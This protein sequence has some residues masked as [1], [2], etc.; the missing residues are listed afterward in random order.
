MTRSVGFFDRLEDFFLTDDRSRWTAI[1]WIITLAAV[2]GSVQSSFLD[3]SV[4]DVVFSMGVVIVL[5]SLGWI[6]WYC[7]V[8]SHG[9]AESSASRRR[10]ILPASMSLASV[11]FGAAI[12]WFEKATSAEQL[13]RLSLA[14]VDPASIGEARLLLAK[15]TDAHVR[16]RSS[17]VAQTGRKFVDASGHNAAAWDTALRFMDYRSS[18]NNFFSALTDTTNDPAFLYKYVINFEPDLK[19]APTISLRGKVA[20]DQA[21][22]TG[23]IGEDRNKGMTLGPAWIIMDGGDVNIDNIELRNVVFRNAHVAY[24]GTKPVS[25]RNVYFIDCTFDMPPTPGA[26]R[27]AL[28]VLEPGAAVTLRIGPELQHSS[29]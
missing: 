26:Q 4:D 16:L 7:T 14:P 13:A 3:V 28:A 18:I 15:A 11:L 24:F 6:A 25:M 22:Q 23:F 8:R 2:F 12:F 17:T 19:N 20:A 21:A 5:L 9:A 1:G 29:N 10:L 27:F